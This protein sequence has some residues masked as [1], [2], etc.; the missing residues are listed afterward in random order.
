MKYFLGSFGASGGHV[1][2]VLPNGMRGGS[3][4]GDIKKGNDSSGMLVSS[5]PLTADFTLS[6]FSLPRRQIRCLEAQQPSFNHEDESQVLSVL[7]EGGE[8]AWPTP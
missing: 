6:P 1:D 5:L 4:R 3:Q 7:E 8:G 2:P